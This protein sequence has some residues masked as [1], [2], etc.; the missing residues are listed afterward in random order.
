MDTVMDL[1]EGAGAIDLDDFRFEAGLVR[2][3]VVG[4][5]GHP[6]GTEEPEVRAAIAA[7]LQPDPA[8]PF[9]REHLAAHAPAALEA[10]DGS[11][12]D[13]PVRRLASL[14]RPRLLALAGR[15]DEL[16]GEQAVILRFEERLRQLKREMA[17]AE[18]E[19][20]EERREALHA[21]YIEVGTSYAGR[22]AAAH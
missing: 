2:L 15:Q 16:T 19:G 5:N 13:A 8:D 6:L 7:C 17:R 9:D 1:P 21:K 18:H 4:A 14:W 10:L 3:A 20:D 11:S 22:L 12:E